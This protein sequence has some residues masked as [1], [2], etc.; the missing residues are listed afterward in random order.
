M[1]SWKKTS[2]AVVLILMV[3]VLMVGCGQSAENGESVEN[4]QPTEN[5]QP[6]EKRISIGTAD[7]G[8]VYYLY[9]GGIAKVISSHVPNVIAT[10]EV[11]PGAVDNVKLIKNKTLDI[12]FTKLDI[13]NDAV[14]GTGP[15]AQ[16]GKIPVRIIAV[17]YSDIAHA[18][19]LESSGIN[20]VEDMAGK[21]I[22][23]NAPGS[24]HELVATKLLEAAGLDWEKDIKRQRISL[25]ESADA[26]KDRKIDGFFFATG[27]PA[28][29]MLDLSN[30][31]GLNYK[32]L[33]LESYNENI[34]KKYGN[35]F[36]TAVI[37]KDTYPK[38]DHDVK[39]IA[40][41]VLLVADESMD[42]NTVYEITKAL[43]EYQKDLI[44]VH[45]QAESFTLESASSETLIPYHAGAIKYYKEKGVIK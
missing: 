24:G 11:T 15:F 43:F 5:S 28:A 39:T 33:D 32:L 14:N 13:A 22:S 6:V 41:P 19:V 4:G 20:K 45:K 36:K 3:T 42:E 37:P 38:M 7:S 27:V 23:T 35:I 30:T 31:Q 18:V 2:V 8:G 21:R 12:A 29:S 44:A 16:E 26:F 10:A 17:L 1:L 25:K 40:V 34:T 9:G